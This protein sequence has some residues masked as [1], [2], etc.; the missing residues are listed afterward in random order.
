[1]FAVLGIV[2]GHK[3]G[4]KIHSEIGKG[5]TIT[6]FFAA[7]EPAA[8]EAVARRQEGEPVQEDWRGAGSILYVEDDVTVRGVG[9]EMLAHLGFSVMTAADGREALEVFRGHADEFVCVLL[10]LTM[11]HMDGL[12]VFSEMRRIHPG[13]QIILCSGYTEQE[14]TRSFI[15]KG[16]TGFIQKPFTLADLRGKLEDILAAVK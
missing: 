12:E 7:K 6:V 3:G 15:G 16:L 5:T 1:M 4:L 14:A 13:V 10:D 2:R 9:V 8:G 11:P